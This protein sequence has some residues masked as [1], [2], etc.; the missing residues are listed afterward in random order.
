MHGDASFEHISMIPLPHHAPSHRY[1]VAHPL[2][3][4]STEMSA[5]VLHIPPHPVAGRNMIY[6]ESLATTTRHT[7][8]P[9]SVVSSTAPGVPPSVVSSTRCDVV[10]LALPNLIFP[11]SLA[12]TTRHTHNPVSVDSSIAPGVPPSVVSSTRCGVVH[13]AFPNLIY[14]ESLATTTRHTHNPVSVDSSIAPSAPPSVV[15]STRSDVLHL[16]FQSKLSASIPEAALLASAVGGELTQDQRTLPSDLVAGHPLSVV[17]AGTVPVSSRVV[18]ESAPVGATTLHVPPHPVAGP[19]TAAPAHAVAFSSQ[20]VE[21][22]TVQPLAPVYPPLARLGMAEDT[23]IL[24]NTWSARRNY[25][26]RI[27]LKRI[28]SR[29]F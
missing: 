16:P 26:W 18:K 20:V 15:S 8:N 19:A 13:L 4:V 21:S 17:P 22:S 2:H 7:H 14:P 23:S 9:R 28:I 10:H 12:T 25:G 11:E 27:I 3:D 5:P 29:R 6:P 24:S 1:T